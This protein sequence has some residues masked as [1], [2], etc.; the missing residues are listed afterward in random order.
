MQL[1]MCLSLA[2]T[3]LCSMTA[4]AAVFEIGQNGQLTNI[5][6]MLEVNSTAVSTPKPAQYV[7]PYKA[8]IDAIGARYNLSPAL[9]DAVAWAES[10][11]RAEAVSP[12]G[13][14]GLMQL[15]PA[16]ARGLGVGD[17]HD[18]VQ[19]INGGAAYLRLQLDRFDGDLERALAAYNA[20]PSAV[21]RYGK[22]PPY[23]ETRHY[24][25]SILNRLAQTALDA[26]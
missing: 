9:V 3:L 18:P 16:T 21:D 22:V 15:M 2:L 13:A 17:L 7:H 6:N 26:P 12:K 4:T 8:A 5:T 23:R 1:Q 20:G 24:V 25:Q 19:N 10:R 14:I 11:Y